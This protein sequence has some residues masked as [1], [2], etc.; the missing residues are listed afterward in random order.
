MDILTTRGYKTDDYKGFNINEIEIQYKNNQL[1][2]LLEEDG[3]T[4]K[5]LVKYH[6]ETK[7]KKKTIWDMHED[8]YNLEEI[9]SKEDCDKKIE[10][11]INFLTE[12]ERTFGYEFGAIIHFLYSWSKGSSAALKN[13]SLKEDLQSQ[14][15]LSDY[16]TITKT[17]KVYKLFELIKSF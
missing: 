2:M 7:L 3:G 12:E 5:I 14:L 15:E 17:N 1:D 13:L 6:L 11:I 16:Q 4:K 10:K 8:I 9:L